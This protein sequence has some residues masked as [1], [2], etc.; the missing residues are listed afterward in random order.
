M[1]IFAQSER[2]LSFFDIGMAVS[3]V[4]MLM[5]PVLRIAQLV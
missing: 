3:L 2:R 4:W 1:D 5:P